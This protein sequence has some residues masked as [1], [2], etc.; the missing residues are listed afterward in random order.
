MNIKHLATTLILIFV[1]TAAL[2]VLAQESAPQTPADCQRIYEGDNEMIRACIDSL[3][4]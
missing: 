2:P 1:S 3:K 4:K